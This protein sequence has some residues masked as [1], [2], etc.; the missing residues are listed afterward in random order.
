MLSVIKKLDSQKKLNLYQNIKYER[1]KCPI[2]FL[3]SSIQQDHNKRKT[4]NQKYDSPS[5]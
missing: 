2:F 4:I 3:K 5:S 1:N